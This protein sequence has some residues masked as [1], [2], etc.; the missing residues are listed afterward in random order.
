MP[1]SRITQRLL[2]W[3][4]A[5]ARSLPWRA[6][7]GVRP[8]PY[9]VWLSEVMLQQTTVQAVMPRFERFLARWPTVE[10]LAAAPREAVL[11]E[12]AGLGY[13]ARARNL[14][15]CAQ[16]IAG[17]HGGR[18]PSEVESLRKLPGIGAYTA[19][20]IA[21]IAFD[22]PVA[23]VDGNVERVIARL[24]AI[25]TPLPKA[26]AEIAARAQALVAPRRA[27]DFAQAMMDL[28][29]TVCTPSRPQC[30]ICP[31]QSDCAA[32]AAGTQE[33]YP[34][35]PKKSPR[36]VR[37]ALVFWAEAEGR[38]LLRRRPERGLLGGM[39]ELPS[40]PWQPKAEFD[41]RSALDHAPFAAN[42]R[43]LGLQASHT[44]THFHLELD[45]AAT[46]CAK[47]VKAAAGEWAPIESLERLPTVMR[48]VARMAQS[49]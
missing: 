44:F 42:W 36:P 16:T 13:Y 27:G 19:A 34:I 49:G 6:P 5:H 17:E 24:D 18:F 30:L 26:K 45:L 2:D 12:W 37:R 46:R 11:D 8:D 4:D 43:L 28:G 32:H 15:A 10:A 25:E 21:A 1:M 9:R 20:A 38:V 31:L 40:S 35:K 48:K 41:A 22:R 47:P 23:A 39:L 33:R 29:A 3:Y 7:K 14:H